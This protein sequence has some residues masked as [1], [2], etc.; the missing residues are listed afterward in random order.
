MYYHCEN[1]DYQKWNEKINDVT[2]LPICC[3]FTSFK[4]SI[5]I[6]VDNEY[7]LIDFKTSNHMSYNYAL[8]LAAYKYLLKELRNINISKAMILRLDKSQYKYYTYEYDLINNQEHI[9]FFNDCLQTF[10]LLCAAFIMRIYT[11]NKY[12]KLFDNIQSTGS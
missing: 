10:M 5:D 4:L 6:K 9:Q 11:K 2:F 1:K 8:Q 12:D 7:W 3:I